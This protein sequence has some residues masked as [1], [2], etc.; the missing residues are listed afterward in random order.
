MKGKLLTCCALVLFGL[1][2]FWAQSGLDPFLL[3]LLR[4]AAVYTLLGLG[5]NLVNGMTGQFSLGHGGFMLVGA[6]VVALLTLTSQQK[7]MIYYLEPLIWPLNAITLPFPL[8]LLIAA[9]AAGVIG[10]LV[11]TPALRVRGDYLALVT[12]AFSEALVVLTQNL[13][14][15]TNGALGLKGIP[16]HASVWWTW[17]LAIA[18]VLLVSALKK[19]SYGRALNAIRQDEIAAEAM[20]VNLY[21]HKML[22]FVFGAIL[23]GIGGGLLA[24]LNSVIDPSMFGFY[25]TYQVLIIVIIGGLGSVTGT[26]ISAVLITF[27]MEALRFMDNP[28]TIGSITIPGVLGIRMVLFS[29]LLLAAILFFSSGLMG[30]REFSWSWFLSALRKA[31]AR[32]GLNLPFSPAGLGDER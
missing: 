19:S 26:V 5:V 30:R 15:I 24:S 23:C 31:G 22:A 6:Y 8:A 29:A 12:L 1:F 14:P 32:V 4:L 17:G 13:I 25:F 21:F 2:L 28:I 7:Q 11:G 20:G 16:D 18:A 10:F 9:I 3:R 27:L